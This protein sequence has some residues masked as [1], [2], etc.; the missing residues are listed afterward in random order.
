[1]KIKKIICMVLS[2]I[3]LFSLCACKPSSDSPNTGNSSTGNSG[4]TETPIEETDV[5]FVEN[6]NSQYKIIIPEGINSDITYAANELKKYIYNATSVELSIETDKN[7]QFNQDDKVISLGDTTIFSGSDMDVSSREELNRDGFKIQRYGNTV[8]INGYRD[9][10]VIYGVYEFLEYMIDFHAYTSD[11]V[12]YKTIDE[13]LYMKDFD[14]VCAPDF[15]I[16]DID[17]PLIS[18]GT[19][20][21]DSKI[22]RVNSPSTATPHSAETFYQLIPR[23]AENLNNHSEWFGT[24]ALQFCFNNEGAINKVYESCIQYIQNN[25]QAEYLHISPCD[26][27]GYCDCAQC[28]AEISQYG[29]SG[30]LIIMVNKVIEKVELWL[31]ENEPNRSLYYVTMAY[32]GCLTFNAPV[33]SVYDDAGNPKLTEEGL[34]VVDVV[35]EKCRPHEKLYMQIIPL[36]YCFS[37]AWADSKCTVNRSYYNTV[38][39]WRQIT[40]RLLTYDYGIMFTNYFLFFDNYSTIKENL[41]YYQKMGIR[42]I[43]RQAATG[44]TWFP[45]SELQNYLY[46]QLTWETDQ[47]LQMLINDFMD[48]YYKDA[49]PYIKEYFYLMRSRIALIDRE[50]ALDDNYVLHYKAYSVGYVMSTENYSKKFVEHCYE[51]FE[52]A[53]AACDETT[54][55]GKTALSRVEKEMMGLDYIHL[56]FYESYYPDYNTQDYMNAIMNFERS[57]SKFNLGY[58]RERKDVST[59][60]EELKGRI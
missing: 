34:A 30:H 24:A 19:A 40:D 7:Y 54:I 48:N 51:L 38:D 16:R 53:K 26:G 45:F 55:V 42:G 60:I 12:A 10:G 33:R 1:M 4:N 32:T 50:Q 22:L 57:A 35:D 20:M 13:K 49:A 17:G 36:D 47:D 23:S 56:E 21:Q 14:L 2:S 46:G 29:Y 8:V 37:H 27:G 11:E 15:T 9:I 39:A 41:T 18:S 43:S 5:V 3:I 58:W 59:L 44:A 25:P 31:K 52:K 6:G 28:S